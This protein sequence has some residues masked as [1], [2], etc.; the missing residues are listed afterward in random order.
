MIF[1]GND[2]VDLRDEDAIEP[3]ENIRFVKRVLNENEIRSVFDSKNPKETLWTLW[4]LKESAYKALKRKYADL[5]FIPKD[6]SV[7]SKTFIVDWRKIEFLYSVVEQQ[8][9]EFVA[10]YCSTTQNGFVYHKY[11]DYNFHE[12]KITPSAAVRE[13][14]K[15]KISELWNISPEYLKIEVELYPEIINLKTQKKLPLSMSHHGRYVAIL[16]VLFENQLKEWLG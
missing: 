5:Q 8:R 2:I 15:K 13:F 10:S 6:F 9:E 11:E 4:S 1:F 14:A 7:N 12:V 16:I 3:S